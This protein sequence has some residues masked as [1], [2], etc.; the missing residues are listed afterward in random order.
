MLLVSP[1]DHTNSFCKLNSGFFVVQTKPGYIWQLPGC[2]A[3]G[4]W[5]LTTAC[6]P[7]VNVGDLKH[8]QGPI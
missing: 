6:Y 2:L 7:T 1:Q 3:M 5:S 8:L 4:R